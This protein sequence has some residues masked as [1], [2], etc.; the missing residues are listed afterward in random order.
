MTSTTAASK[1]ALVLALATATAAAQSPTAT[2]LFK[3]GRQLAK[4]GQFAAACDKFQKSQ[5]LDPQLGTLFNIAQCDEKIGKLATALVAYREVVAK[6]GNAQRRALAAEYQSKLEPRVPKIVVQIGNP[7]PSLVVTLD[8]ATG[9]KPID[10][11]L[12]IEVDLGDYNVVARAD[13]YRELSSKVH[14]DKEGS[15]LTVPLALALVHGA[16]QVVTQQQVVPPPPPPARGHSSRKKYAV[17][18]LALGGAATA[19]GIVFGVLAHGAWNDAQS[20]CGGTI[21]PTQAQVDAANGHV[22]DARSDGNLSTGFVVGGLVVAGA[23]LALWL[24]APSD[25]HA[26]HVTAVTTGGT[27]SFALSGRF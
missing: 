9:A 18:A 21:C 17:A 25:E 2:E 24:T 4:S 12:P 11:N 16:E 26:M 27:T 1:V 3:E 6:D 23:G 20:V 10:V 19:T 15:T 13:G 7:P 22:S 8:G 14:V 5:E